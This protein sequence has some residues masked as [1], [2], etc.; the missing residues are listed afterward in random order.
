MKDNIFHFLNK[1]IFDLYNK[2][3]QSFDISKK[4]PVYI[5]LDKIYYELKNIKEEWSDLKSKPNKKQYQKQY[6]TQLIIL[7]KKLNSWKE[8]VAVLTNALIRIIKKIKKKK[9]KIKKKTVAKTK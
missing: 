8:Q 5:R 9:K 2:K 1:I 6:Q 7:N 3:T 4:D